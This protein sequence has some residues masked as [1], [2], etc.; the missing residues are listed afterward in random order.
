[1]TRT[2]RVSIL[3]SLCALLAVS[4]SQSEPVGVG[5]GGA[6]APLNANASGDSLR[7]AV[8]TGGHAFDVPNFYRLFRELPGVDAYP[9]HLEH[10]A[11]SPEEDRDAYD[12]VVFYG[13]DQNVPYEEGR[14]AG[15]N[16]R[17]AIE[18][19]VEQGQGI[20]VLH[21]ALLAWEQWDFWNQLTGFDNRNF[22]YK[23]G[24][25]LQIQVADD[26]HPVT[27]GLEDFPIHDEGYVLHGEYDG[28]GSVLLTVD[29]EDAMAQAAWV[30]EFQD[31]R[32]CCLPLGHDQQAW[33]N[34]AFR[35]VLAQ[36]IA[37]TA[38]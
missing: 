38:E 6:N 29:H 2:C 30:R 11:S 13:M 32:V 34:P 37:W 35:R 16:A 9:Q 24:L 26:A 31:S 14:R 19:L 18:R 25:D 10:F 17:A 15:G 20:V 23:E 8:L 22:R 4:C 27:A 7:V 1:M 12:A 36:A 5:R 3:V 33:S 28:Q 21:H